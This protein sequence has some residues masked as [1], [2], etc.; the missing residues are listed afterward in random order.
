MYP[1]ICPFM[2][3]LSNI[4]YN[5]QGIV[6]KALPE[7]CDHCYVANYRQTSELRAHFTALCFIVLCRYCI[8]LQIESLWQSCIEQSIGAIFPKHLLTLCLWVA[9][10]QFLQYFR[11]FHYYSIVTVIDDQRSLMLLLQKDYDL[12]K[13]QMTVSKIRQ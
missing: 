9:F 11:H 8:F 4:L 7:F 10:G 2:C 1:F 13:A 6:N 12:L 5:I 3:I